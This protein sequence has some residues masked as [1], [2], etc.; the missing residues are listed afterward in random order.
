MNPAQV[1]LAP[2][3]LSADFARLGEAVRLVEDA[4]A[5]LIHVDV[6]DGAFVPNLTIGPPVVRAL[7]RVVRV[8]LDVH[9][10]IAN[11]DETVGWYLDAGAGMVT[12]HAEACRHLHRV[13][14]AIHEAGAK[15]GVAINP[16]TPVEV[17]TDILPDL[18]LA[19]V[20]SVD[21]GFGG[22]RF[23]VATPAK[24]ARLAALRD[25]MGSHAAI[26]VDGGID[27]ATA[28]LVTRAGASILVAGSAVFRA[29]DPAAAIAALRAAASAR[30]V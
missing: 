10:M 4:G 1:L 9:L 28:P 3:I 6:M 15:A 21:P 5:D 20:M 18:D 29:E 26:A 2:S 30:L 11:A 22:Q 7:A 8:P 12:V 24:V 17:L 14:A 19:L 23:I 13:I 16:A 27:A 25:A